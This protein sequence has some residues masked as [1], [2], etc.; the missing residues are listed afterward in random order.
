MWVNVSVS[1]STERAA[2]FRIRT[3]LFSV[4]IEHNQREVLVVTDQF[5][6]AFK[7]VLLCERKGIR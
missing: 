7:S 6:L 4:C 3:A 1:Q 2:N 5:N